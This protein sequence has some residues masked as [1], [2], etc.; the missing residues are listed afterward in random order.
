MTEPIPNVTIPIDHQCNYGYGDSGYC[1]CFSGFS[2]DRCQYQVGQPYTFGELYEPVLRYY[3]PNSNTM[4][5][6]P[7]QIQEVDVNNSIVQS[8]P[9]GNY[10]NN[11]YNQ[12]TF[13]LGSA[14]VNITF[15][16]PFTGQEYQ[17]A[18]QKIP[19]EFG[20]V[21]I[22]ITVS[23]WTFMS[24]LNTLQIQY[25]TDYQYFYFYCGEY[26]YTNVLID[27][28]MRPNIY[29]FTETG[30]LFSEYI[31]VTVVDDRI[32]SSHSLTVESSQSRYINVISAPYFMSSWKTV[33]V[34]KGYYSINSSCPTQTT[35]S[36]SWNITTGSSTTTSFT[37]GSPTT[38]SS[39]NSTT[40][41][42]F[43]TY[44]TTT[45]NPT[46]TTTTSPSSGGVTTHTTTTS[47][48]YLTTTNTVTARENY[49]SYV[50]IN[51]TTVSSDI[52]TLT[53][54]RYFNNQIWWNLEY[55]H[56]H[57]L[58]R[59]NIDHHRHSNTKETSW[60]DHFTR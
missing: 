30:S 53:N 1:K 8:Y 2:G 18:G 21:V 23:N 29:F 46:T 47:D 26:R 52:A 45:F 51:T 54:N 4:N 50:V 22:E 24:P 17:F 60:F 27:N 5:A 12:F 31:N 59:R 9:L 55:R 56:N 16:E 33:S 7:F 20:T 43:T 6:R 41:A 19:V 10:N 14:V 11:Y 40:G 44:G 58:H 25:S 32:M 34:H 49:D 48:D 15:I 35:T 38:I 36:S 37:T 13:Y 57:N 3:F 28:S 42:P 39:W